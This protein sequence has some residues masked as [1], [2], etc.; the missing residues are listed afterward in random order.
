MFIVFSVSVFFAAGMD[1]PEAVATATFDVPVLPPEHV[2]VT[3]EKTGASLVFVTSDPAPDN[4][5]YFHERSWLCDESLLLFTS[6]RDEGGLMGYIMATGELVRFTTPEGGLGGATADVKR[7]VFYALRG[8]EVLEVMP[9]LELSADPAVRS[10]VSITV[11]RIARIPE[12]HTTSLN[13][14]CDGTRLSVGITS[15]GDPAVPSIFTI[16]V[17]TGETREVCR[18]SEP[19][20]YGGHVQ[21]SHDDPNLL[22]FA[23]REQ[24][25]MV[26]DVRD[27][28]PR[29]VYKAREDELVTH[30]SW[31]VNHHMLFCGGTHPKP[32]EDS[33]VKVLDLNTGIVRVVGAGAWWEGAMPSELAKVNWW[34]ASGS[35]DGRWVAADNWHGDIMLFEGKTTRPRLLT[36]GHRTYGKG[37]HPHV[38]WDRSGKAVVFASEKHG[39]PDVCIAYIPES[40][41][42]ENP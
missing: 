38:G 21:W 34:H 3:D 20:G 32:T 13:G 6:Q 8:R 36:Q 19:P 24:R 14:N 28:V 12:G 37:A 11:R 5:L 39:N 41:Q 9:K 1:A 23:G 15:S 25:L 22:S 26:V 29:N 42:K 16:D 10:K 31:W 18:L 4:N 33:H 2:R 7:P 35:D 17:T 27:G 30:E 40:W